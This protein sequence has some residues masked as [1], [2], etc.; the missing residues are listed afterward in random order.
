MDKISILRVKK[1]RETEFR[2]CVYVCMR[3]YRN[4]CPNCP[5][6]QIGGKML[7]KTIEQKLVKAVKNMGGIAP[8]F[9]SPGFDGMSKPKFANICVNMKFC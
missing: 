8:K 6:V 3:V 9:V 7:E 5:L 2:A 4:Q 1:R